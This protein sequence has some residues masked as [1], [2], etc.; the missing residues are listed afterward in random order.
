MKRDIRVY[1][2]D[3]LESID[4]IEEYTSTL[5]EEAFGNSVQVQDAVLRRFE[6]IGEA[7]KHIPDDFREK[8]PNI[9]WKKIAGMRDLLIHGYFGVNLKRV[10]KA[11][12][13]DLPDLKE[14]LKA[15]RK[16]LQEK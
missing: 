7:A 14:K 2:Q 13:D 16:D 3:I 5:T 10:W 11:V 8:Y 15:A 9:L 6:I 4:R 12:K 1:I